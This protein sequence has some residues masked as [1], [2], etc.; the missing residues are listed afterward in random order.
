MPRYDFRCECGVFEAEGSRDARETLCALGHPAERLPF[1][2]LP[3]IRGETVARDIPDVSYRQ[4]AE[5]KHLHKTWGTAERSVELMRKNTVTDAEGNRQ[6]DVAGM[7][8]DA[9]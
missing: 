4:D 3:H 8:R 1:S 2:G 9:T 5:A 7:N 6:L